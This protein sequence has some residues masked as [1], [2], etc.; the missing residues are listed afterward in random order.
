MP[1][2]TEDFLLHNE[3][4][5]RLYRSYAE[6]QPIFDY[7][8]HL[9]PKDLA[10]NRRFKNLFEIWLEG[11]HYKW[12]AMRANGVAERYCT[13]DAAPYEK[14]LA[15]AKTVPDTLRNPLYH[16][17]HLE[18]K[19]YFGIDEL[20]NENSARRIWNHTEEQLKQFSAQ[21][22]VRKFNVKVICTT[23]DP[24][25][26]LTYQEQM[27][28]LPF[29]VFPAFRPDGALKTGDPSKFNAWVDKLAATANVTVED[30]SSLLDALKK[31]HDDFHQHGCRLS[32]H[33]LDYC[34]AEECSEAEAR[35]IFAKVRA[36][37]SVSFFDSEKF[38]SYLMLF[39]GQL[40]AARGWTKQLHLGAYRNANTRLVKSLGDNT[41]FDSIGDWPQAAPLLRYLDRL[42]VNGQLPKIIVY[43]VNPA[44]NYAFATLIGNFQDGSCAGKLQF[45][46]GWWFLDQK[47]AIQWQLNALSNCGLLARFVG[48]LTDSR[49]FMSYP[50]HEYFRR[51]LCNLLG[52]EME[53]GELPDDQELVGG[54]IRNIC[55]G[56]A[57]KY[58]Q[59][60]IA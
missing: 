11:D 33:G 48:M 44:D 38:A 14:F 10:E 7:H 23:D 45:G 52:Q 39:F 18:L 53:N 20:L 25:E 43:N 24:A 47:E 57:E 5:K 29:K 55:F 3:T 12:R 34:L 40:D 6:E 54:M 17:T 30:L 2:I 59:L 16:W 13:G 49:S 21:D 31:R 60:P 56:N 4:A 15:W 37:R 9:P 8:C 35:A 27:K 41:G 1:F 22:I 51:V 58:F 26:P 46:S 28:E 42:D 19:R 32:D 50:R 36:G